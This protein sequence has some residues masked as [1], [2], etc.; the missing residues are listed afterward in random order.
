MPPIKGKPKEQI[1]YKCPH[2]LLQRMNEVIENGEY[3]S[4]NDVI[5]T[6]LILFFTDHNSGCKEQIIEWLT[7]EEGEKW[8]QTQIK[9]VL[10]QMR[11]K[12]EK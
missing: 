4:R 12:T 5:T 10:N 8:I 11:V 9:I 2:D 6:A 1:S 3:A 7:S